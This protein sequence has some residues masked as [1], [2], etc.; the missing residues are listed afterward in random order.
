MIKIAERYHNISLAHLYRLAK[1]VESAWQ[2]PFLLRVAL[3]SIS[4]LLPSQV[5]VNI[6]LAFG[7]RICKSQDSKASAVIYKTQ[8]VLSCSHKNTFTLRNGYFAIIEKAI[9]MFEPFKK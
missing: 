4:H 3:N 7:L 8:N 6:I 9:L 1:I 5:L 2:N